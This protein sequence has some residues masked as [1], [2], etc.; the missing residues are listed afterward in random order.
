MALTTRVLGKNGIGKCNSN[1]LLLLITCVEHDLLLTNTVLRLPHR[2]RTS[3]MHSRSRHCHLIEFVITRR[4]RRQDVTVTKAMCGADCWTDHKVLLS[5]LTI[6]IRRRDAEEHGHILS[7]CDAFDIS[8]KK[9]EVMFQPT[10][11]TN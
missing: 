1:G 11:Q 4:K 2:N 10:P 6:R 5:K 7:A 9:T 3:W 8:T